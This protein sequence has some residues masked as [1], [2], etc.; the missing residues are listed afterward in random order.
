M[1]RGA[2]DATKAPSRMPEI[3]DA[4]AKIFHERGYAASSIQE[5][6]DAVGILKGSLYHYI[7]SK[8]DLL[9]GIMQDVLDDLAPHFDRWRSL[10]GTYLKR[11]SIF[12]EEYTEHIIRNR[13]KVRVFFDDMGALS[14]Q[15]RTVINKSKDRYD[16]LLRSLIT[17]GQAEGSVASDIDA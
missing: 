10:Q 7:N 16:E 9:F 11:I 15:H 5:V 6:A 1:A 2:R 8:E 12:V 14:P 4:A 17:S 13:V 3:L